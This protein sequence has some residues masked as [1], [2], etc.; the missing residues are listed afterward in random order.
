MLLNIILE[1]IPVVKPNNDD[2]DF[3]INDKAYVDSGVIFNS[4]FL[5]GLS[6]PDQSISKAIDIIEEKKLEKNKLILD[7][8][9]GEYLDKDTG[10]A[11]YQSLTIKTII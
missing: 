6:V 11:Q 2:D 4:D 1:V 10:D 8:K 5:N 9:I 7:L 3:E